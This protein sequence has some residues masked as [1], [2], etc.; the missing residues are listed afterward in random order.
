M[1]Y[2]YIKIIA[3]NFLSDKLYTF[4]VVFGLAIGLA[5]LLVISQYIYFEMNFDMH[6]QDKERIYYTYVNWIGIEKGWMVSPFQ[7]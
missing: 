3:R 7:P 5:S 6:V 2:N 1:I 4:I